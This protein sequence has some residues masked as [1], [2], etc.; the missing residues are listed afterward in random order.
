LKQQ[1]A[2]L[3]RNNFKTITDIHLREKIV[4]DRV[5]DCDAPDAKMR[6]DFSAEIGRERRNFLV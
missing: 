1:K 6:H 2:L 5:M 3:L 4:D